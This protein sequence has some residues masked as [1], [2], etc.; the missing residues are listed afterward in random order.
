MLLK[1][2]SIKI[3]IRNIKWGLINLKCTFTQS[4]PPI[5]VFSLVFGGLI[6]GLFVLIMQTQFRFSCL[7]NSWFR[8]KDDLNHN[9][10]ITWIHWV[11]LATPIFQR[12]LQLHLWK[13][14]Q[15]AVYRSTETQSSTATA[16]QDAIRMLHISQT[17]ARLR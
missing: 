17:L 8:I 16:L 4:F 15:G 11:T 2:S 5:L 3:R 13:I 12:F 14:S 7:K 6:F 9:S 10:S 1:K